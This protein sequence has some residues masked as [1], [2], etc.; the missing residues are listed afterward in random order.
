LCKRELAASISRVVLDVVHDQRAGVQHFDHQPQL[1][2][3]RTALAGHLPGQVDQ[4]RSELFAGPRQE[5]G[6]RAVERLVPYRPGHLLAGQP[7]Q[8][9]ELCVRELLLEGLEDGWISIDD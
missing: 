6:E 9:L 2:R 7:E 8:A 1:G 5:V 4:A 3:R